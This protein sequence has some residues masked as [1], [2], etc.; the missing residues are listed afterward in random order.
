MIKKYKQSKYIKNIIQNIL[1]NYFNI[2]IT[3]IVLQC[4]EWNNWPFIRVYYGLLYE[5]YHDIFLSDYKHERD[6][7]NLQ[8]ILCLCETIED[9][10]KI[11]DK[12][13]YDLYLLEQEIKEYI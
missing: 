11:S 1:E 5:R 4:K 9:L 6:K 10:K 12:T 2:K 7:A 13:K 8:Q 3:K